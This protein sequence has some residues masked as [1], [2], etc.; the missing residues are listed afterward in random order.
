M[1]ATD[2][3]G[4]EPG[5]DS[6][7]AGHKV[8]IDQAVKA[9][10]GDT[11]PD[12]GDTDISGAA[13]TDTAAGG[14]GGDV[15][16]GGGE[17]P[18]GTPEPSAPDT[19]VPMPPAAPGDSIETGIPA[20]G[21]IKWDTLP[22]AQK[23]DPDLAKYIT[24]AEEKV[25]PYHK[26]GE[27]ARHLAAIGR[28]Y[29]LFNDRGQTEAAERAARAYVNY[30]YTGFNQFA[31][32]SEAAIES[33]NIDD[34]MEAGIR[35][36]NYIPNGQTA[37]YSKDPNGKGYLINITDEHG[38]VVHNHMYTP[39]EIAAKVLGMTPGTYWRQIVD[40][41]GGT[42]PSDAFNK[43]K[44]LIDRGE[45]VPPELRTKLKPEEMAGMLAYETNMKAAGDAE[46]TRGTLASQDKA[47]KE[48][49]AK[50]AKDP[51]YV[52]TRAELAQAGPDVQRQFM[53]V[54]EGVEKGQAEA[55]QTEHE[56]QI[57]APIMEHLAANGVVSA[58]EMTLAGTTKTGLAQINDWKRQHKEDVAAGDATVNAKLDQEQ[59]RLALEKTKTGPVHTDTEMGQISTDIATH[60]ATLK[61]E[62]ISNLFPDTM[63]DGADG[64]AGEARRKIAGLARQAAF[65]TDGL[66]GDAA[67]DFVHSIIQSPL[68]PEDVV[69]EEGS[70]KKIS[71]VTNP[72]DGTQVRMPAA[73]AAQL[74]ALARTVRD[75]GRAR[76]VSS[77]S[78][79]LPGAELPPSMAKQLETVTPGYEPI[80]GEREAITAPGNASGLRPPLPGMEDLPVPPR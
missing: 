68:R 64:T 77:Q 74:V 27:S 80:P 18:P 14:A 28:M 29:K 6:L 61:P 35:A 36:W 9:W 59:K 11:P 56:R 12:P 37:T 78:Q 49:L 39:S 2:G 66:P 47:D 26:L 48:I 7:V 52:P 21:D 30:L 60:L 32:I 57:M 58:D 67:V 40:A 3:P 43:V 34:A 45:P 15:I 50:V 23:S 17:S 69:A 53:A 19:G 41:A 55:G 24:A 75:E 33:G 31:A 25:D 72:A 16:A 13:P 38:R 5:D 51:N 1:T 63:Q 79:Y 62:L 10:N 46:R 8:V 22:Q 76:A 42:M 70:D 44:D 4:L 20:P 54:A 73:A 71:L 65:Y